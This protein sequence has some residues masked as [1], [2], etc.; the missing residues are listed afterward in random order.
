MNEVIWT[1]KI[2]VNTTFDL[3]L[4]KFLLTILLYQTDDKNQTWFKNS[5]CKLLV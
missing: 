2:I 1:I 5:I 4:V 3:K